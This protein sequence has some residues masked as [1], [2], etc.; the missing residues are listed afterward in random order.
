MPDESPPSHSAADDATPADTT[1]P[2]ATEPGAS[3]SGATPPA[4]AATAPRARIERRIA[5]ALQ[6]DQ[7]RLRR[8]WRSIVQAREAGRPSDRNEQKFLRDL[9]RSLATRERRLAQ[10]PTIQYDTDLP[11]A[12]R[13]EE[14]AEALRTNQVI[15]VC[16]ETGS[17]KSTQLPKICLEMGRGITGLIGHTQ[18]RRI[19]ARSIATRI[20]EELR[21]TL[22]TAVGFKVRFTDVT[23]PNTYIKLM[24]DGI[25]LAESQND[26]FLDQYDTIILDEAHERS[27]NIDLLI[28]Y[29]KGLLKKRRDLKVIIT[30]AT[31][32]A[33]RFAEHF[34]TAKGPAPIIEVSGRTYPVEVRYRPA[35]EADGDEP[36]WQRAIARAIDEVA[37]IDS[38]DVLVFL[39]TERDIHETAKLLRGRLLPGDGPGRTTEILPLYA[40][41]SVAE[42]NRVFQRHSYRRIVLATNVAESSLTVPGIRFVIDPGT[43]RISRYA[44]RSKMQRLPIEAI[45]QASANQ[46]MGRS[47]RVGPGI[48][49]RLYSEKD[50]LSREEFTPPEILRTNL[51]SVILQLK[52]LRFGEIEEF[53]FLEPPKTEAIRDGYKTLFELGALDDRQQLTPLGRTL[54]RIPVD[55]RVGRIILAGDSEVCL[56]D[57][58]II[59]AALEV[60]EPRER[61]FDK[62]QAADECHAQFVCPESD[63]LGEL[64]LW[65]FYHHLRETVSRSQLRKACR[66]N[67]LSYNRM[68]EW[69]D[70]HQQL[71][72]VVEQVGLKPHARTNDSDAI[73]RAL[74]TGLLSN[75][76]QRG[77]THEYNVAGGGKAL[78]WPGSGTFAKKPK[79]VVAAEQIETTKRYLRTVAQIDPA[80]VER[81]ATH[82]VKRTYSE[83]HWDRGS[84]AAMAFER[85]SLFGLI[86]VPR[87]RVTY[88]SIDP[89]LSREL[90]LR[91]G[92]VEGEFDTRAPFFEHNRKLQEEIEELQVRARR[93]SLLRS[94]EE[95][96]DFYDRRI[97]ADIY[98]GPRF[99][100][101]RRKAEHDNPQLL[102]MTRDDLLEPAAEAV[103][104]EAYPQQIPAGG[105]RLSLEYEFDPGNP[106]DGITVVV[107]REGINQLDPRR[108][109][110]L[111][112]GLLEEKVV[113][114][115]RSLPK[116]QRLKFVPVNDTARQAMRHLKF[117][118]GDMLDGL[119]D[120][121]SQMAGE[122]IS[123]DL[124]QT[125][126]LPG[127]LR[128]NVRVV[129]TQGEELASDRNLSTLRQQFAAEASSSFAALDATRWTRS[130]ITQW[131]FGDLPAQVNLPQQG[132]ILKGYP[133]LVDEGETVGL[134]LMDDPVRA[135]KAL[136]AGQRRLFVLTAARDLKAQVNHLPGLDKILL[137]AST[138]PEGGAIRRQLT[139]LVADRAF[140]SQ[141]RSFPRTAEQFAQQVQVARKRLG[142]AIQEVLAVL[143]GLM[144]SY[145]SAKLAVGGLRA[146]QWAPVKEDV[147]QQMSRLIAPGFLLATPWDWLQ[148]YA[149]Y[150]RA[151]ERRLKK[152]PGG[153]FARDQRY[154]TD[155][156]QRWAVYEEL[157]ARQE[158]EQLHDPELVRLR[159]LLEEYRVLL[160]AQELGTAAQV[161]AKRLDELTATLQ[162]RQ[163][164]ATR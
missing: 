111:V 163:R 41:L 164:A 1:E 135:G 151:L 50:F 146:P 144:E 46:R 44:P 136:R 62:Q 150:F 119:A 45:S 72:Q 143:P 161:S 162:S 145:Q 78:V 120:V 55:P 155:I 39:P 121:L 63:F 35:E 6:I 157:A 67:F 68:Q 80:W 64:K 134:Q 14:I 99:E 132:V 107:P 21:T 13:R 89:V 141:L 15:I 127:H 66:Q 58:L 148:Q 149:R 27:L 42:Q 142:L 28:G 124:F 92:L 86:V 69:I 137:N 113:A 76:A 125:D 43:A 48:C 12:A 103:S 128:M 98:D 52:S 139:E 70:L 17:G 49:L 101:W 25:L 152:L 47:G 116:A 126:Q 26:R 159:W 122:P 114:L 77:E 30:S 133:T 24:T 102:F 37:A 10:R 59:A 56:N 87:R 109:G 65:D 5:S 83:P 9:E 2:G 40:R 23:G 156:A 54:S 138:L 91:Q 106:R 84:G 11:I 3:A 36:D 153:G 104:A 32:D 16:G 74:L 53:P 34:A 112:P 123:P 85:V 4:E 105:L 61:P 117:G 93:P 51:A 97:P 110:W 158:A 115:I 18:P 154:Q 60:Q 8:Q 19:A 108:L 71:L 131:D 100:K 79:W 118:Q 82:L 20:S 130:G 95:R 129:D 57:I 33:L 90:F 88:G 29:L 147:R 73:H 75:I 7:H 31:I 81:L 38:G 140:F 160:F 22:G 96:F 94:D